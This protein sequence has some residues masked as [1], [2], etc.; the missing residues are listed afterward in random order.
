M[1]F[2]NKKT[3]L[4]EDVKNKA[5]IEQYQKRPGIWA[6]FE[7]TEN[8]KEPTVK[9][10][11]EKAAQLGIELQPNAKKQEIADLITEAE[12]KADSEKAD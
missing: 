5:V 9:E 2:K 11:K 4:V 10:L 1:K 3:G 12:A 7:S 8:V 6:S